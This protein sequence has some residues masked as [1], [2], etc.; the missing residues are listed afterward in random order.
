MEDKKLLKEAIQ[1]F[2]IRKN[3]YSG[4]CRQFAVAEKN[5]VILS[6]KLHKVFSK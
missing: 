4:A 6:I 2:P 3:F 1:K 5:S